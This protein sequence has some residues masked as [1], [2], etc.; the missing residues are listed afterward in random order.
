MSFNFHFQRLHLPDIIW[1]QVHVHTG[2]VS[3]CEPQ[4]SVLHMLFCTLPWVRAE[5]LCSAIPLAAVPVAGW[6]TL[7]S[8]R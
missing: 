3:P 8:K 4:S 6:T 2:T 5:S 7:A 1:T